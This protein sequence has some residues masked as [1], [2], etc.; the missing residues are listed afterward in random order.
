MSERLADILQISLGVDA[1]AFLP[2]LLLCGGI[3][4]MLLI[5]LIPRYDRNN[6]GWIALVIAGFAC[7][8]AC[9]QWFDVPTLVERTP[10]DADTNSRVIFG[11]MLVGC[12][13]A[14]RPK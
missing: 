13:C 12:L 3:V 8:K 10:I 11:G 4:L 14:R 9:E 1:A 5:R 2:E 7:Y 6:I